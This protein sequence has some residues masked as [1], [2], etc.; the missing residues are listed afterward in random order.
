MRLRLGLRLTNISRF[1]G[2]ILDGNLETH[3]I[4]NFKT[5]GWWE[6]F[7]QSGQFL[8]FTGFSILMASLS[9]AV[10]TFC[11]QCPRAAHA[12]MLCCFVWTKDFYQNVW[13]IIFVLQ[14]FRDKFCAVKNFA[15]QI[16]FFKHFDNMRPIEFSQIQDLS[17]W[18]QMIIYFFL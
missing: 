14:R 7:N 13:I 16:L 4:I 17:K 10:N 3:L 8:D 12:P 1:W 15:I 5:N 9:V 11:I 2:G 6:W 18:E